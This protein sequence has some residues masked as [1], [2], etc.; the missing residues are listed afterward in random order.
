MILD[1]NGIYE[2]QTNLEHYLDMVL[3]SIDLD[4]NYFQ[5]LTSGDCRDF[6]PTESE[7]WAA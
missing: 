7:D 5:P 1:P 4:I 3:G 6:I 2:T